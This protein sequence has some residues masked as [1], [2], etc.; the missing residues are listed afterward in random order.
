MLIILDPGH[1]GYD[2][3]GGSNEYF[4]EKDINLK[5]SQYQARRLN[6]LGI[7]TV[8]VRNE[9]ITLTPAERIEKIAALGPTSNDILISNHVNFGGDNGG[10]VIYSVRG[11]RTLPD[12]IAENLSATGL[13]IR[14]IY[15]RKNRVGRDF[16]FVLRETLPNDAII[17]E[18]GFADNPNDSYRIRFEWPALAEAVVK[19]LATYLNIEYTPSKYQTYIVKPND[20]LFKIANQFNTTIDKIKQ[21]NGLTSNEIYPETI[22]KIY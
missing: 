16:Y 14:N 1:G 10:E 7:N 9:D 20:S 6:E 13:R 4:K 17:I 2:P 12:L 22:L 11:N 5:I 18:Y 19:A 3:G 21:D 15:Q 8:L